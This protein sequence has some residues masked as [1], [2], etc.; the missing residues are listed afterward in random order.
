MT[1]ARQEFI[2]AVLAMFPM[3]HRGEKWQVGEFVKT[4]QTAVVIPFYAS[5]DIDGVAEQAM[6]HVT[7]S[8][9]EIGMN[10]PIALAKRRVEAAL[11][12]IPEDMWSREAVAA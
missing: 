7:A 9:K 1:D 6:V 11:A 5:K 2:D 4:P 12:R 10:D 8:F 3:N